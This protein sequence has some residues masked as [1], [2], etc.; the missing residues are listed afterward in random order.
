MKKGISLIVLI[1]TIIVVIILAGAIIISINKNNPINSAKLANLI[2]EKESL[3]TSLMLYVTKHTT[4]SL[5]NYNSFDV[6]K[7]SVQGTDSLIDL[8][9]EVITNGKNIYIAKID[10]IKSILGI[11]IKDKLN[12]KWYIDPITCE[13]YLV[14]NNVSDY[15]NYLGEYDEDTGILHN[16][17]I[18]TFVIAKN[19]IENEPNNIYFGTDYTVNESTNNSTTF[20]KLSS[21]TGNKIVINNKIIGDISGEFNV[22]DEIVLYSSNSNILDNFGLFEIFKITNIN[23]DNIVL[24]KNVSNNFYPDVTQVIKVMNYNELTIPENVVVSPTE[25]NGNIGGIIIVKAKKINLYG[26]INVSFL[27]YKS[28][29]NSILNGKGQAS[30]NPSIPGGSN[31]YRGGNGGVNYQGY[32]G[33]SAYN[34]EQYDLLSKNRIYMGGGSV[35][36]RGGG[37]IYIISDEL[38]I[39]SQY[40]LSANGKGGSDMSGG[41]AGGSIIINSK[42][43]NFNQQYKD[44]FA[45][46]NGGGGAG[47][48]LS[49][50]T[51][52]KYNGLDGTNVKGGNGAG[53]NGG[54]VPGNGIGSN[55]GGGAVNKTSGSNAT[56]TLAGNGSNSGS[57]TGGSG[58]NAGGGG[59][60]GGFIEIYTNTDISNIAL[61]D[62]YISSFKNEIYNEVENENNNY[63]NKEIQIKQSTTNATTFAKASNIEN[64]KISLTNI[65]IGEISSNFEIGDEIMLYN[66]NS[67]NENNIGQYEFYKIIEIVNDI[68][69]L[70]RNISS[71]FDTTLTQI[72][73][74][75]NYN[76]LKINDGVT[77]SPMQYDGTKGGIVV[78]KSKKIDLYGKI[79]VSFLGYKSGQNSPNSGGSQASGNPSMSGGSNQYRGGN[80]GRNYQGY[81]GIAKNAIGNRN[82][83]SLNRIYM[84]G[85]SL[86]NTCGGGIIYLVS[87]ELNIYSQYALSANGKGGT[88]MSGGGAGGTIQL[89]S[90]NINLTEQYKNY[91]AG[92]N[93][94]GGAGEMLSGS[95]YPKYNGVDGTNVKGGNGAGGNGG[96]VPGNGIGSNGGGGAVNK[97]SGSNATVTL[98]GNGSNSAS[99]TGGSGYNAGGGG[100][101]GGFVAIYTN[102]DLTTVTLTDAFIYSIN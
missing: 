70:D 91:F 63:S 16:I 89:I 50:S 83:R 44:Y 21:I 90:N 5:A 94:G 40:A 71:K 2:Q 10:K 67:T 24:N 101:A 52:P 54:A 76:Y 79:D 17:N 84:G 23:G 32:Q 60:A 43:I 38:N 74:V 99:S 102:S 22:N 51:Y 68:V 41:G 77:I 56:T 96:A 93:G 9:D 46:A 86:N 28:E 49:G 27:G 64:N 80:G 3:D 13:F 59:G 29:Y 20:A 98:A 30:G 39:E 26:K 35:N 15:D 53:G 6:V 18:S 87:D 61:T 31:K 65:N 14:Y 62:S 42:L 55:G 1:I 57:S 66:S 4:E 34:I 82:L 12:S 78:I 85:G 97:T 58:Y 19:I 33:I 75:M 73:K 81:Y 25:Y 7:G 69:T 100:G 88:S 8:N 11:D 72:I 92:A 47:E 36:T 45:G 95:T 48:I 37:A